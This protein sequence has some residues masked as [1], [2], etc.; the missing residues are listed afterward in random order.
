VKSNFRLPQLFTAVLFILLALII[1]TRSSHTALAAPS[2]TY[3][4]NAS[5]DAVDDNPGDG[6]C[7]ASAALGSPCTL[8]AAVEEANLHAGADTINLSSI[9]YLLTI[10]GAE[11]T[12]FPD[13]RVGDLDITDPAGVT[14]NGAGA[15]V[16][17]TALPSLF[18]DAFTFEIARKRVS[19]RAPCGR[20]STSRA[21]SVAIRSSSYSVRK[22]DGHAINA[23][24][25][26]AAE[27][28]VSEDD[29]RRLTDRSAGPARTPA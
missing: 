10:V 12:N 21:A 11:Q 18:S 19:A 28:G 26:N 9:V 25:N 1:A 13:V 5:F 17:N 23:S 4:V 24:R 8:R 2:F 7:A 20:I 27:T 14:I 16:I 22:A 29:R 15:I 6:I 3:T